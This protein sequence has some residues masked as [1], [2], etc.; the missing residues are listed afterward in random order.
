LTNGVKDRTA[1]FRPADLPGSGLSMRGSIGKMS[2]VTTEEQ[3]RRVGTE[4]GKN[5]VQHKKVRQDER[6]PPGSL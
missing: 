5:P 3:D 2:L 6:A 4:Q 1:V